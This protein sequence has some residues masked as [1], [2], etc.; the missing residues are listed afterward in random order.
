MR[1]IDRLTLQHTVLKTLKTATP[2]CTYM[3]DA[4]HKSLTDSARHGASNMGV[5]TFGCATNN[6]IGNL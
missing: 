4:T 2:P 5:V 3:V 6:S 1:L